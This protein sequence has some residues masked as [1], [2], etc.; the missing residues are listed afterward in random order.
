MGSDHQ[1]G[2]VRY[3]CMSLSCLWTVS[4]KRRLTGWVIESARAGQTC[5]W[6]VDLVELLE[7]VEEHIGRV[8]VEPIAHPGKELRGFGG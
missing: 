4:W 6:P 3:S 1:G 5:R 2:W 7:P 8:P